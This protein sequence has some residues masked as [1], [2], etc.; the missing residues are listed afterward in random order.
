MR[1]PLALTAAALAALAATAAPAATRDL[2]ARDFAPGRSAR[3]RQ[4]HD[5]HR[6][7]ASRSMPMA[8][9]NWSTG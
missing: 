3:R 5:P 7:P 1:I 9:R 8:T 6:A 4:C 2:P